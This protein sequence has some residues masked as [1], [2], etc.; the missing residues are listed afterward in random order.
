MK[1]T[2]SVAIVIVIGLI[3]LLGY[4]L[5]LDLLVNLRVV[6]LEWAVILSAVALLV[7][8]A[9][10]FRVH[11]RKLSAAQPQGFFSAVLIISFLVTLGVA[12]WFGPTHAYSMWIF[13]NIQL[14][15]E[16]S[17]MAL[18]TVLLA[19]AGVRLLRRKPN[20][21][22]IVFIGTAILILFATGPLFGINLPG[23]SELR[24]WIA[25]VPAVAGARGIL[26]GVAL[27]TIATGLRVLMGADRPYGG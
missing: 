14:P 26:L 4:F 21:M 1:A 27:G 20:L 2:F 22:S 25:Q 13:N 18:L 8:I 16:G 5:H 17:L 11:W 24:A 9:N 15:I 6:L 7:G 23:L 3:V 12:G 19:F 10:L